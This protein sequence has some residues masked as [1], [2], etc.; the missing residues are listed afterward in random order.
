[1]TLGATGKERG[2]RHPK[3]RAGVLL[4]AGALVLGNIEIGA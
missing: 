2:D 4:G 1:V 3:V